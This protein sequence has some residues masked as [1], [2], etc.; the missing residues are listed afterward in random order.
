MWW[1]PGTGTETHTNDMKKRLFL[2]V[3]FLFNRLSFVG[4]CVRWL[5][6]HVASPDLESG[7]PYLVFRRN[8]YIY[9]YVC[10]CIYIYV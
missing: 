4:F 2:E 1:T 6:I 10:V 9:L 3:P 8:L 7:P 5:L